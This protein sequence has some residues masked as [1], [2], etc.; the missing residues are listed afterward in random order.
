MNQ[1][2]RQ[3][4]R[5]LGWVEGTLDPA[6]RRLV[7]EERSADSVLA[8]RLDAMQQDRDRIR[9]R[10][11]LSRLNVLPPDRCSHLLSPVSIDEFH[12]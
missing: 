9:L 8:A 1:Q 6:D 3:E 10:I 11:C 4:A 5:W 7:E 2:E 12:V